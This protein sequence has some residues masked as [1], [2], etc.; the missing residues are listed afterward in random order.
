MPLPLASGKR[1]T[2]D[3]ISR[4]QP[5]GL[6]VSLRYSGFV[7][8]ALTVGYPSPRKVPVLSAVWTFLPVYNG[9]ATLLPSTGVVYQETDQRRRIHP[10]HAL[11]NNSHI[12]ITCQSS[13]WLVGYY[14]KE[15]I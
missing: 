7:T 11:L 12:Q 6:P 4:L 1:P 14:E 3:Q 10:K 9:A 13:A 5:G 15:Y 8:V 2:N